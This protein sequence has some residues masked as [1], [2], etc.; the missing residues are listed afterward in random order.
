VSIAV[1]AC[2]EHRGQ[3]LCR[4]ALKGAAAADQRDR[5]RDP[6]G[7]GAQRPQRP[8]AELLVDAALR[9]ER[10]PEAR[11]HHA[12]LR[13]QAVDR[14][15]LG[16]AKA[17]GR[18][19]LLERRRVRLRRRPGSGRECDPSLAGQRPRVDPPRSREAMSRR[20][21]RHHRLV[22]DRRRDQIR[23]G[24]DVVAQTQGRVPPTDKGA[25]LRAERRANPEVDRG[26]RLAKAPQTLG[27]RA[28][29][30]G[31]HERE[32]GRPIARVAQRAHRLDPVAHRRQ[33]RF[34]MRQERA[35]CLGQDHST[36][37]ALEQRGAELPLEQMDAAA[38][39]G[40]REMEA[41]RRPG[42]A[43]PPDDGDERFDVIQ[44]HGHQNSE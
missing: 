6:H 28:A 18:E 41:R 12:L 33:Q 38:D 27:Q 7:G 40:L 29:G 11:L 15:D 30:E 22:V 4:S 43:A 1:S 23:M 9:Q 31:P 5:D 24:V 8:R 2:G 21:H 42:E 39:R 36:G 44:L 32:R 34:R 25:D 3:R 20:A 19:P 17:A 14:N 16:V 37:D 10:Q 26:V 13:R 35:T